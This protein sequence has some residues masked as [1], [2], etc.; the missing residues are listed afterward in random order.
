M[1]NLQNDDESQITSTL[2]GERPTKTFSFAA[3]G[4]YGATAPYSFQRDA[5]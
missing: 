4:I 1:L 5:P 3:W 2:P